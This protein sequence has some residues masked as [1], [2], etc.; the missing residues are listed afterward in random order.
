LRVEAQLAKQEVETALGELAKMARGHRFGSSDT[1]G[2]GL[3][4]AHKLDAVGG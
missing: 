2:I 3:L 4:E 1:V